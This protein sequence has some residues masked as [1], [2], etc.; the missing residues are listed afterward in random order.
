MKKVLSLLFAACVVFTL[1]SCGQQAET[2]TVPEFTLDVGDV[3]YKGA[4]FVFAQRNAEHSTG[5][6]YFGYVIN[7]EFS[8]LAIKRI[9]EVEDKLAE[10]REAIAKRA[11]E[12]EER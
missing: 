9:K 5:D 2:E 8:D 1:C 10:V 4:E 12:D 7:T 11:K 6:E 3:D